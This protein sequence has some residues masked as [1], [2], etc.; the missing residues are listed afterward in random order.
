MA[1][2]AELS[3]NARLEVWALERG[4]TTWRFGRQDLV[5]ASCTRPIGA[6]HGSSSSVT[7]RSAILLARYPRRLQAALEAATGDLGLASG[8]EP[9]LEVLFAGEQVL[10]TRR[11]RGDAGQGLPSG[12]L[13]ALVRQLRRTVLG[14]P[15]A[16]VGLA[17]TADDRVHLTSLDPAP[18]LRTFA[19]DQA[20]HLRLC[21]EV[22]RVSFPTLGAREPSKGT[23][24]VQLRPYGAA[25]AIASRVRRLSERLGAAV[26]VQRMGEQVQLDVEVD[27]V[28]Q[29]D[30]LVRL[31]ADL[32]HR[33]GPLRSQLQPALSAGDEATA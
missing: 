19:G 4:A 6:W 25:A 32:K 13:E 26:A 2:G 29:T 8:T 10:A 27:S 14:L 33:S 18:D 31:A 7:G 15:H 1:E 24:E 20:D 16:A 11:A 30:L 28:L 23:L 12:R 22:A 21:S 5:V 17:V 3:D 9:E